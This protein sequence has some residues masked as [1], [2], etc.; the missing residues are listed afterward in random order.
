MAVAVA[1]VVPPGIDTLGTAV[2]PDPAPVNVRV[3]TPSDA[4]A[5]A[6]LPVPLKVTA[7]TEV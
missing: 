6:P 2:Y 4:V 3:P 1:L 5:P 7:G